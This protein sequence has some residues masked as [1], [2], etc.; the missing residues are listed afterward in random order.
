MLMAQWI[1]K[2]TEVHLYNNK[3]E[4]SILKMATTKFAKIK[5]IS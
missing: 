5:E 3:K 1:L 4:S 2:T